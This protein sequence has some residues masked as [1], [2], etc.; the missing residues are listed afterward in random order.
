MTELQ[1]KM[2]RAIA[3]SEY[4]SVNGAV[5]ECLEDIDWVWANTII[6]DAEDKGVFT[7]LVNAG[8][9]DHSGHKGEDASVTLTAAG[10]TAY[11]SLT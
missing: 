6:Y 2:I 9:V 11:Q 10:F 5:P 8:L 7:S 4:T 1:S 3:E